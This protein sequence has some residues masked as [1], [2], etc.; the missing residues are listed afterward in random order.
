MIVVERFTKAGKTQEKATA[1]ARPE[2]R[3]LILTGGRAWADHPGQRL[4]ILR[5]KKVR[6]LICAP[7][8]RPAKRLSKAT[9]M[10]ART[11]YRLLEVNPASDGFTRNE[12]RPLGV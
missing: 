3:A 7:T 5:A 12:G 11:I 6:C 2:S 1:R 10:E 4:L 8:G 9:G